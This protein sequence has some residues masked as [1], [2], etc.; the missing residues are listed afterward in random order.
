MRNY[1]IAKVTNNQL[2]AMHE[3]VAMHYFCTG[4]ASK[5]I[6]DEHLQKAYQLINTS[7]TLPDQKRLGGKLLEICF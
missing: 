6:E 1:A 3:T 2:D 7:V 4:T 5:R